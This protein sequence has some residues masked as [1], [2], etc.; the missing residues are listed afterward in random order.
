MSDKKEYYGH[1]TRLDGT[2][3]MLS[4]EEAEAIWKA[5]EEE[6]KQREKLMPTTEEALDVLH[7]AKERLRKLGWSDGIYCPK[8]GSDF[9]VIEYGSTGIFYGNYHGEWPEGSIYYCDSFTH[10]KGILW[11]ALAD[12]TDAE[13]AKLEHCTEIDRQLA[14]REVAAFAA[15]DQLEG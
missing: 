10:P 3:Q 13:K 4:K 14:E 9:A 12:L 5:A 6:E 11:K 1:A 8:D 15:M 2:H 7:S